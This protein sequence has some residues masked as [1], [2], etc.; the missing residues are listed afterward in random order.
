M[1]SKSPL[2]P[3]LFALLVGLLPGPA[4]AFSALGE[5]CAMTI[6]VP[7]PELTHHASF[8]A[9]CDAHMIDDGLK[10]ADEAEARKLVCDRV[11][12]KPF[13]P[14]DW[15]DEM[16]AHVVIPDDKGGAWL[17]TELGG[18]HS[19]SACNLGEPYAARA[20]DGV[21]RIEIHEK[22]GESTTGADA[23]CANAEYATSVLVIDLKSRKWLVRAIALKDGDSVTVDNGA[24][25]A[26]VCDK[27]GL[28][29]TV[30]DLRAGRASLSGPSPAR[31]HIATGRRLT[32]AG[33]HAEAIAAFR[34]GIEL[35]PGA[36]RAYSG[37][38]YA[39]LLAADYDS[40]RSAFR[41][42]LALCPGR[43]FQAAVWFNMGLIA[44]KE[45]KPAE[46]RKAFERSHELRPTRATR[47]RLAR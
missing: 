6:G 17:I 46:A 1:T 7:A 18:V 20:G 2:R 36:A 44:E 34:K 47:R 8:K 21:Y 14:V 22:S 11:E 35:D 39:M 19:A 5:D 29:T 28:S 40:A 3:M 41:R 31:S 15:L 30:A 38:G 23:P 16:V 26:S 25:R 24:V 42:A 10:P 12:C 33:D 9:M 32:R 37:M 45:G 13:E 4:A 27:Q 43:K